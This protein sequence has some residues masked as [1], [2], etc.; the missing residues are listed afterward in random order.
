MHYRGTNLEIPSAC[1]AEF[2]LEPGKAIE[3]KTSAMACRVDCFFVSLNLHRAWQTSASRPGRLL[4]RERPLR[5]LDFKVRVSVV[6]GYCIPFAVHPLQGEA[7]LTEK[8]HSQQRPTRRE[9]G[10]ER[11]QNL[12]LQPHFKSKWGREHLTGNCRE[13][14]S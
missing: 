13:F 12:A 14:R 9:A 11:D 3:I 8:L 2:C 6:E 1:L 5:F 7:L 4:R 10:E